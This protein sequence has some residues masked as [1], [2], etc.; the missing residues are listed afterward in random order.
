MNKE[1]WILKT[2]ADKRKSKVCVVCSKRK[3]SGWSLPQI[4]T[5][6]LLVVCDDCWVMWADAPVVRKHIG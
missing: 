3:P 6:K 1:R 4:K 5:D 2:G